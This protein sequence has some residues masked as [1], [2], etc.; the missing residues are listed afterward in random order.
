[1]VPASEVVLT[2]P[3]SHAGGEPASLLRNV[4]LNVGS[5]VAL[6]IV[7]LVTIPVLVH[8]LGTAAFGVYAVSI[9]LTGLTSIFDLGL[10][11]AF[12]TQLA[13]ARRAGDLALVRRIVRTALTAFL[14]LGVLMAGALSAGTPWLTTSLLHLSSPLL[15]SAQVALLLTAAG[16]GLNLW[17]SALDAIPTA[18]ERYDIVATRLSV[19]SLAAAVVS[20][21]YAVT[22]GGLVGLVAINVVASGV[23]VVAFYPIA[24]RLLPN[25]GLV[26]GMSRDAMRALLH[27][28][29]YKFAGT[30]SAAAVF[31]FDQLAIGALMGV[32]ATGLYAVPSTLLSRM[33]TFVASVA[34]PFF[35]RVSRTRNET[36]ELRRLYLLGSRLVA[37]VALPI[38]AVLAT[39]PHAILAAWIGGE[40]G[41]VVADAA[42]PAMRWL[43]LAFAV[44]SVA[45]IPALFCEATGRPWINNS[46]A[47]ASLAIHIP[48]FFLLVPLLGLEG[49][50]VALLVN[51]LVQTVPFIVVATRRVVGV[52]LGELVMAALARPA[53]AATAP[54]LLTAAASRFVSGRTTLLGLC[55][56]AGFSYLAAA[57]V[58]GAITPADISGVRRALSRIRRS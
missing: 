21:G 34:A 19:L 28:S 15:G 27:F 54:A 55:A 9:S 12:V 41:R 4:A 57:T 3:D 47:V 33:L 56:A 39:A 8:R 43:A 53:A 58:L 11:A 42:A 13:A 51:S 50:G 35:P 31:R 49:A 18:L 45:A 7:G 37:L 26:P 10:T 24:H 48:L 52:P 25:V 22:G 23:G 20:L 38:A 44:Q 36:L 1:M 40:E 6:G 29:L 30:A 46:F 5:R 2:L 14:C 32:R 16:L 17:L